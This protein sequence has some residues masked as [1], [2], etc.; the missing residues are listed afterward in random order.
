MLSGNGY[1]VR[2]DDVATR[3]SGSREDRSDRPRQIE[4]GIHDAHRRSLTE[5]LAVSAQRC[6]D[7]TCSSRGS[8]HL[9]ADDHW[10]D[11]FALT[12]PGLGE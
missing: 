10:H 3:R 7:G 4:G 6:F 9:G 8:T 1:D 12:F 5:T 2:I 11:D